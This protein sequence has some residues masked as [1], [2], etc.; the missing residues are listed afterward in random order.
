MTTPVYK[1]CNQ[2]L[3]SMSSD[4]H[5]MEE[6]LKKHVEDSQRNAQRLEKWT[7]S[8]LHKLEKIGNELEL[9]KYT[10]RH[11]ESYQSK[12]DSE[13]ETM[14]SNIQAISKKV[15]SSS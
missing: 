6:Q 7:D 15:F 1:E 5:D 11:I 9:M 4:L 10:I 8:I 12:I 2:T 14:F 3:Q 13:L